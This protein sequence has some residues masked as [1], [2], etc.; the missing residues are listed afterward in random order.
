MHFHK[1]MMTI[2]I[3]LLS[4]TPPVPNGFWPDF[5]EKI[6]LLFALSFF[7]WYFMQELKIVR[8]HAENTRKEYESKFEKMFERLL[9]VNEESSQANEKLADAVEELSRKIEKIR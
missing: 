8:T 5:G 3:F 6:S 4:S 2:M 1:N 7:L 9:Q